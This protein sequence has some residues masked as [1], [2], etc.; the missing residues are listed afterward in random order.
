VLLTTPDSAEA[1]PM[2]ETVC[3]RIAMLRAELRRAAV[4][5]FWD[6]QANRD[7]TDG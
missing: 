1:D 4:P 3:N 7:K 6:N 5:T 2:S